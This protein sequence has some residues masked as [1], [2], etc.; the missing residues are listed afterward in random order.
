MI[1]YSLHKRVSKLHLKTNEKYYANV[2]F[3]LLFLNKR[4]LNLY[5][6]LNKLRIRKKELLK[7]LS[8][9]GVFLE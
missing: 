1:L 3:F 9:D 4:I 6:M 5:K 7:A 2:D 8:S